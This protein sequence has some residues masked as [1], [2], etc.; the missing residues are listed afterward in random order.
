MAEDPY[1]RRP[2]SRAGSG[3]DWSRVRG[4]TSAL[5]YTGNP[6]SLASLFPTSSSFAAPLPALN[7]P[8]P[9]LPSYAPAASPAPTY[10]P[11]LSP[12][13]ASLKRSAPE[14]LFAEQGYG[15]AYTS[16]FTGSPSAYESGALSV[17]PYSGGYLS[18]ASPSS[19]SGRGSRGSHR[20]RGSSSSGGHGYHDGAYA[21]AS[22]P[23]SSYSGTS[24]LSF[25]HRC[26]LRF[27][28][29]SFAFRSGAA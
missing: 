2:S 17:S 20:S 23:P 8:P 1:D 4:S 18:H 12:N 28:P 29:R 22:L 6:A 3:A 15:D 14:D 25:A 16:D 7:L 21:P 9:A 26:L 11:Y 10:D 27:R 19:G 5:P 24:L 13:T